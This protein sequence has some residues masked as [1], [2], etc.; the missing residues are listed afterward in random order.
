MTTAVAEVVVYPDR[1]RIL[2]RGKAALEAGMHTLVVSDLPASLDHESL[3]ASGRGTARAKLLSV[4]ASRGFV[5]EPQR[6]R[7]AELESKIEA[8]ADQD[9]ELADQEGVLAQQSLYLDHLAESAPK[10]MTKGLSFGK[11]KVGDIE[12][13]GRYLGERATGIAAALRELAIHRRGVERELNQLRRELKEIASPR[14]LELTRAE[15]DV[16]VLQEGELYLEVVYVV[17]NARWHP[18][19]DLRVEAEGELGL[20]YLGEVSQATGEDW[21]NSLVSLSTAKPAITGTLP[22]L[23]PWY[24]APSEPPR[25]VH[26][27]AM[28]AAPSPAGASMATMDSMAGA[29]SRPTLLQS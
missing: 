5:Q 1:A 26:A 8:L 10:E 18:V 27:M 6:E 4:R 16:E 17:A 23:Q 29:H 14:P 7:V 11:S 25:P 21:E 13:L 19:Y 3:R 24:V 20:T 2:R 12:E 28:R 15:I 9:R 22:E